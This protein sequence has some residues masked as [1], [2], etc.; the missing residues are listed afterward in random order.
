L[1][2][3]CRN[4]LNPTQLN[5]TQL[6]PTQLNPTQLNPTQRVAVHAQV[7]IDGVACPWSVTLRLGR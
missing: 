1:P 2:D 6:N 7:R 5:P 3:E 4:L